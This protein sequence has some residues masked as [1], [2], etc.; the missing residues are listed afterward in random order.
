MAPC[1]ITL[2]LGAATCGVLAAALLPMSVAFA[3]A[4][5]SSVFDPLLQEFFGFE[6]D[7]SQPTTVFAVSG[8]PPIFQVVHQAQFFDS[9]A[10]AALGAGAFQV[11]DEVI[12]TTFGPA[13][14]ELLVTSSQAHTSAPPVGSVYDII[15]IAKG[16]YNVYADVAP[17]TPGGP[18]TLSDTLVTPFGNIPI[19]TGQ[20]DFL[21]PDNAYYLYNPADPLTVPTESSGVASTSDITAVSTFFDHF[22]Q[23]YFGFVHDASAPTT[24]TGIAAIPPFY[25]SVHQTLFIDTAPTATLPAGSFQADNNVLTGLLGPGFSEIAVTSSEPGTSAP[26]V[27]SVYEINNIG[28][29]FENLYSDIAPTTPG[30]PDTLSDILVTPFGDFPLMKDLHASFNSSYSFF[31]YHPTED[32]AVVTA[33]GGSFDSAQPFAFFGFEHNLSEPTTLTW[34][35]GI[36]PSVSS[37]HLNEF[38]DSAATATLAAGSFQVDANVIMNAA[39]FRDGEILVTGSTGG[40]SAPPVGSV[41][42][43][44]NFGH[45]VENFYS[46]IAPTTA[47]APDALSDT[48]VTPFGDL[49]LMVDFHSFVN[50]ADLFFPF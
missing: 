6:H 30:G 9:A 48:L 13:T 2:T 19:M 49:P 43:V 38:F 50:P 45:G 22:Y 42:D 21:D 8:V 1:R 26:P 24:V 10:T 18:D 23:D 17:T 4:A 3:D 25:Q 16:F 5:D 29:G 11:N 36:L 33:S 37:V 15:D 31:L 27:G 32:P 20:H 14:S 34:V 7:A 35:S 12:T 44:I 28:L 39:G 41:F 40:T 46:D 47:G